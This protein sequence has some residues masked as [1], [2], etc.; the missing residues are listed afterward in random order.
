MASIQASQTFSAT[1]AAQKLGVSRKTIY[2]YIQDNL[3]ENLVIVPR[4][5]RSHYLFTDATIEL[6]L[7]RHQGRPPGVKT[8]KRDYNRRVVKGQRKKKKSGQA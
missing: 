5:E 8:P 4:A 6:F 2:R 7:A 1:V 3:F